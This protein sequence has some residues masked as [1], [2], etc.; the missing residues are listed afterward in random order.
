MATGHPLT[1][2]E[3]ARILALHRDGWRVSAIAVAVGCS[4]RAVYQ[5]LSDA[6]IGGGRVRAVRALVKNLAAGGD[7][8]VP[9]TEALPVSVVVNRYLADESLKSLA[10]SYQVSPRAIR[11]LLQQAGVT[12]RPHRRLSPVPRPWTAEERERCVRLRA[13]G[14]DM[15]T[16]GL[17][18]NRSTR[19]VSTWLQEHNRPTHSARMAARAR[20][21]RGELLPEE[22]PPETVIEALCA[23]WLAGR[24]IAAMAREHG[25]PSAIVSGTLKRSG[26]HVPRGGPNP[27]RR[28]L[29]E[30]L[31]E[32]PKVSPGGTPA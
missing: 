16:I 12:I 17:M 2:D 30:I 4:T 11:H 14:L 19:A 5:L 21:R 29:Q 25:I 6:R 8:I 7:G 32:I 23:G 15:A 9:P 22:L 27:N 20:R 31:T 28:D 10:D 18:V 26:L 13:Q 24:G 1:A 3:H